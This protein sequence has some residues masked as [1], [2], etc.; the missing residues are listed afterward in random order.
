MSA[1]PLP[2]SGHAFSKLS[3]NEKQ[4]L[5]LLSQQRSDDQIATSLFVGEGT[6]RNYVQSILSKLG[7]VDRAAAIA[8][9][10]K[11]NLKG[12]MGSSD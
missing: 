2:E 11:H 12:H 8:Y 4:V 3:R 6:I 7:Q 10:V 1:H 9:A 5:F